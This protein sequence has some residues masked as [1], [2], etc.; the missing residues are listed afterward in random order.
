M[1]FERLS[2]PSVLPEAV[3]IP[4]RRLNHAVLFVRD[5]G[6]S[7]D[8]Y[9]RVLGFEVIADG[10]QAAFLRARGS[11][12][13][14]DLG[15]FALGP[16]GRPRSRDQVGLYHLAWEVDTV[17]DLATARRELLEAGAYLGESDHGATKS[18]YGTDPDGNEFEIMWM[19]PRDQWGEYEHRA[20]VRPLDL[21]REIA[22]WHEG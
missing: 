12:N 4:V 8:F 2:S 22:R 14:H 17:A 5:L 3:V 19:L 6:R 21:E 9:T 18:V 10:G 16:T 15:L 1:K 7:V 13:H 11:D 20:V